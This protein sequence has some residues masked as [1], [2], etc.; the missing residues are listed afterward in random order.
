M[1]IGTKIKK[2]RIDNSITQER[3]ADY[4]N[5]SF[6]AVSKWENGTSLPDISLLKPLSNFFGVSIDFLLDNENM[7]EEEFVDGLMNK[8]HILNN[9]GKVENAITLMRNGLKE[10]PK[11]YNIMSKLVQ[12]LITITKSTHEKDMNK[13]A[14]EAL[15]LCEI[16]INDSNDYG[17]IDSAIRS[18]FYANIDLK[19][20][21]KAIAIANKR[22]SIG[23]SKEILLTSA[24]RGEEANINIQKTIAQLMRLLSTHIF[25][26]TYKLYG[27][28]RYTIDQKI[29]IV[30]TSISL[31]ESIIYD[32]NYLFYSARLRRHYTFLG[33]F[34]AEK[35]LKNEMYNCL[36]KSKEL[37]FYYDSLEKDEQY[38][39]VILDTQWNKPK[40]VTKN[41][42]S[43]DFY[44]FKNRLER[45]EFNPYREEI[46]FQRLF[47]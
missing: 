33:I 28:D 21:D 19:E 22:P 4:L 25:S 44:V 36:E 24:Y 41:S 37:A 3:L 15:K 6:Q 7:K 38:T 16:I 9:Q 42:E 12:S 31:I 13:N 18:S 46:R 1:K 26:L 40:G 47:D 11:N 2:L 39:S 35:K 8:Y 10:Y 32:D 34:Y 23:H 17:L 29:L 14:K 20:F 43:T 30:K 27:G 45:K 5:I